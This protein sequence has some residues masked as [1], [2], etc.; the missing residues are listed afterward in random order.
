MKT[1]DKE[2]WNRQTWD[3][4]ERDENNPDSQDYPPEKRVLL[5]KVTA[6]IILIGLITGFML[7]VI[8]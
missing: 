7:G 3:Y 6:V 8:L 1:T 4:V 5:S 2:F